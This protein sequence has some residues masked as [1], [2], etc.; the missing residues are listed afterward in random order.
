MKN[1]LI[2]MIRL[3]ITQLT[4]RIKMGDMSPNIIGNTSDI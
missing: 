1:G 4:K 3:D 2:M